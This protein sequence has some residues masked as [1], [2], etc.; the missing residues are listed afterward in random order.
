[1]LPCSLAS[2]QP[3]QLGTNNFKKTKTKAALIM[4]S[5]THAAFSIFDS[6][7]YIQRVCFLVRLSTLNFIIIIIFFTKGPKP[8]Q[9]V[10]A[11]FMLGRDTAA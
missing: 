7:L 6:L 2:D 8:I 1:M 3:C 9:I 11:T 10:P 4:P 5:M